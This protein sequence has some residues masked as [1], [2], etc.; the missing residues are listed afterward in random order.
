MTETLVE[1]VSVWVDLY[2]PDENGVSK[3]DRYSHA[4]EGGAI[5]DMPEIT[6]P[7]I[8]IYLWEWFLDLHTTRT[9]GF[10]T[11]PITYQELK[12]WTD[13]THSYPSPWEITVLRRMDMRYLETVNELTERRHPKK[14]TP[15]SRRKVM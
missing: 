5:V 8:A 4:E 12:A 11:N 9:S 1:A 7:T 2:F 13:L 10:S 14:Q 6:V 3:F 15:P